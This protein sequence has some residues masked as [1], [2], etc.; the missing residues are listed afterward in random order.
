MSDS[1]SIDNDQGES[2]GSLGSYGLGESAIDLNVSPSAGPSNAGDDNLGDIS[3]WEIE[4]SM[5]SSVSAT[6]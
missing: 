5:E 3:V 6:A 4:D 2:L 1:S